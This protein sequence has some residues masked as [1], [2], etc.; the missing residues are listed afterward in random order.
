[1]NWSLEETEYV[2]E[3]AKLA[4]DEESG[5]GN[6]DGAGSCVRNGF[7]WIFVCEENGLNDGK[8]DGLGNPPKQFENSL[9]S[10]IVNLSF[11]ISC[12]IQTHR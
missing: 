7:T 5:T 1:M 2:P 9:L 10:L 4:S 3:A 6:V 12:S 11:T 8:D